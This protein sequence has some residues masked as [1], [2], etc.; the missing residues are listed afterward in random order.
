MWILSNIIEGK[1]K[2]GII[3]IIKYNSLIE[4]E[5]ISKIT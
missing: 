3:G 1:D 2:I 4:V 5:N